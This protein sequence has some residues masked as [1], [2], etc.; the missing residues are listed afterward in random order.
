MEGSIDT[1]SLEIRV[2][3]VATKKSICKN[4]TAEA[5][6]KGISNCSFCA[7]GHDS[8]KTK[9]FKLTQMDADHLRT[10]SNGGAT[11]TKNCEMLCK[12]HNR[13]KGNR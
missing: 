13:A 11:N 9:I 10:W 5:E 8:N 7:I 12:A 1:K 2:F 6:K 3:D 4:Q